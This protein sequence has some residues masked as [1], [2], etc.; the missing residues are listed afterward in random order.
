MVDIVKARSVGPGA[1]FSYVVAGPGG[2]GK[3]WFLGTM[4]E[5]GETLL[6]ATLAREVNSYKYQQLDLDTVLLTDRGW[7]PSLGR[8]DATMFMDFLNLIDVLYA[9][10]K[11]RYII[12][13]SGTELAEGAWH[14]SLKPFAVASPSEIDDKRSRWAPYETLSNLLDQ[15]IKSIVDLKMAAVPKTVGIAWHIQPAKDDSVESTGVGTQRSQGTKKSADHIAEGIEYEGK[16]LPMIRGGFRRKLANLVDAYIFTDL[17]SEVERDTKTRSIKS[18]ELAYKIQVKPTED[19]HTKIPG[20][21]PQQMYINNDFA[22]FEALMDMQ[23]ELAAKEEQAVKEQAA[24]SNVEDAIVALD[25]AKE[26]QAKVASTKP[27]KKT[28]KKRRYR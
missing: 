17:V 19:R 21:L 4:A 28:T 24:A 7:K 14:E 3:S 6:I 11:Y 12:L 18:R 22:Q 27:G 13:D 10:E 25:S 26:T 23:I 8:Y 2:T 9:D 1:G 20:P 5:K 16:I 15:A